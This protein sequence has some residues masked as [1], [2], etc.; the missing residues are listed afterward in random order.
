MRMAHSTSGRDSFDYSEPMRMA[1][2]TSGRDSFQ[3]LEAPR[4]FMANSTSGRDGFE[5]ASAVSQHPGVKCDG[6]NKAVVGI[7]YKC[8]T[9]PDFDLC[10]RCVSQNEC[11]DAASAVHDPSHLFLRIPRAVGASPPPVLANRSRWRHEGVSCSVCPV[12]PIVGYRFFC[13]SCG[14]SICESCE[15]GG[16]HNPTHALLKMPK[17]DVGSRHK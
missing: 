8:S 2:S 10:E 15:Q 6:C 14:V 7:R 12:D 13:T 17:P 1:H 4:R 5:E 16:S 11:S 9:C 3:H